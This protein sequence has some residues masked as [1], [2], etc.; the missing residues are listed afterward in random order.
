MRIKQQKQ[1][2][3]FLIEEFG[4]DKGNAL[5]DKQETMLN[6]LIKNTKNKT[7]NQMKTLI[8]TILPRIALYKVLEKDC[9]QEED[10]YKYMRICLWFSILCRNNC[11]TCIKLE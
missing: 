8:Q 3:S 7:E 10:V 9:F 6:E 4:I 2:K 11:Y 1:I 5:F